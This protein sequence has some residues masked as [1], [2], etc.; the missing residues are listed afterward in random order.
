MNQRHHIEV[1]L[2]GIKKADFLIAAVTLVGGVF[3]NGEPERKL[4]GLCHRCR[5]TKGIV[6]RGVVN[7][8][9]FSIVSVEIIGNPAQNLLNRFFMVVGDDKD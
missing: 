9:N 7:D 5:L 1:I 6:A 8:Q 3:Q 2:H 4:V